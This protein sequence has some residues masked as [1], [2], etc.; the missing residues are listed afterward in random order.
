MQFLK[1][2]Y[3]KVLLGLVLLGLVGT[4]VFLLF[5]VANEKQ[6]QEER[7][8]K[9][10]TRQVKPLD[11]PA[12]A[13]AEE[14]VHRADVPVALDLSSTNKLFNPGRWVKNANGQ[15]MPSNTGSEVQRIQ[16]TKST[17]L[18]FTVS[19]DSVSQP[20]P[21]VAPR[22]VVGVD[23][24]AGS[25]PKGKRVLYLSAGEK[26]DPLILREVKGP[27]E[28]P[29]SL[30]LELTDT[31]DQI[32]I[33]KDKPFRRVD[34]YVVDLKYPPENRNY[35]NKRVD[36][37]ILFGGNEYKIVAITQDEVVISAPN[38]KHWTIK[39]SVAP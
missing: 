15:P 4:V 31:G 10:L 20:D 30:V 9:I 35:P 7:R 8:N 38:Q 37:S 3:E 25:R 18:Y 24:Q 29:T 1:K 11:P 32:T 21:S 12:L 34:G 28:N 36:S 27:A 2:N 19:F 17:P 23:Q 13:T 6:A 14:L 5:Y 39:F 33:S 16:V 22:Y 26:K